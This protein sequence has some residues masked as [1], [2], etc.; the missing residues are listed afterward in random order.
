M[1]DIED[2]ARDSAVA[3]RKRD[4]AREGSQQRRLSRA[5]RP[6]HQSD[7]WTDHN[8][9]GTKD[10]AIVEEDRGIVERCG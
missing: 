3:P 10:R 7:A 1:S 2:I 6:P 8:A 4:Q 5:V 9:D